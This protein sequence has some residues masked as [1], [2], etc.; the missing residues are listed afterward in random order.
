MPEWG[1]SGSVR[2]ALSNGCSYRDNR[3]R[4]NHAACRE[5]D[6]F[7][8]GILAISASP[9]TENSPLRTATLTCARQC[10]PSSVHRTCCVFEEQTLRIWPH[11]VVGRMAGNGMPLD[12]AALTPPMLRE[13]WGIALPR[14]SR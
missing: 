12:G 1:Q 9:F 2:G 5:W 13:F 14:L 8:H 3:G 10:V 7:A 4:Q 6:E 11:L